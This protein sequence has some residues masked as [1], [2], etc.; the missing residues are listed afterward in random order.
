MP[1]GTSWIVRGADHAEP[2]WQSYLQIAA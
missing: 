1:H 2:E